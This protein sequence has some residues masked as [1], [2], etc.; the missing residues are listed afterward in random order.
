ME[1]ALPPPGPA[2]ATLVALTGLVLW[3]LAA[4]DLQL[5][6]LAGGAQGFALRE[7]WLL[8]AVLHTG[9][10]WLS[11][12][13]AL[14]LCVAVWW[15]VGVLRR[16]DVRRRLQLAATTLLAA[17]LVSAL[18]GLSA[19]SCPWDLQ[20][21]GGVAHYVPHWTRLHD[22]GPGHC[23]PAGHA[24]AGFAFVGGYF[25]FR[26]TDPAIARRWLAA[27]LAVGFVLGAA[28]Q[29]RGAHFMS[30]TLW[31]AWICW[32]VALAVDTA[33]MQSGWGGR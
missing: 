6:G 5:A 19:T 8:A 33:S 1:K 22:G 28:Q 31:S 27:S 10:R 25:C 18:K 24:S 16:L 30:H 3:D 26:E 2:I 14:A 11:W 12:G 32:A 17:G 7:H 4:P 13:L 29:V 23:F 20:A 21:F 15:P 9:A